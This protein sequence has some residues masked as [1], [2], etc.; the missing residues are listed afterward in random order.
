MPRK[1][2]IDTV[3]SSIVST[4]GVV[5][6]HRKSPDELFGELFSDIQTT[7]L[8]PDGKTVADLIPKKR[9][10]CFFFVNCRL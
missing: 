5:A 6:R 8:Y 3:K 9:I 7:E 10:V 1:T 4:A 2:K